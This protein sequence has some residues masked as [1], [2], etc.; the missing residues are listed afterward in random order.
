[1]KAGMHTPTDI[2]LLRIYPDFPW[3]QHWL[4][5][6]PLLVLVLI[7]G[8][9][10]GF[11]GEATRQWF[12]VLRASYPTVK[13]LMRI[14]SNYATLAI[15]SVYLAILVQALLNGGKSRKQFV[16]RFIIG[17]LL[18]GLLTHLLKAG[19]GLPRPGHTLPPHPFSFLG[20]YTSFPSGHTVAVISAAIL[21]LFGLAKVRHPFCCPCS[22][23]ESAY[24]AYGSALTIP[25][26]FLVRLSWVVGQRALYISV[27]SE[28]PDAFLT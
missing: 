19:F 13:P 8:F 25:L 23:L 27:K 15:Y 24:P 20:G 4:L 9:W 7:I 28:L 6:S 21:W 5:L 12:E 3:R 26:T 16:L 17:A 14:V 22:L 1:M 11:W 18:F 10:H 2:S